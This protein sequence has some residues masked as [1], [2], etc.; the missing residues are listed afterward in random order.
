MMNAG[1]VSKTVIKQG[2]IK[3]RGGRETDEYIASCNDNNNMIT[4]EVGS[5]YPLSWTDGLFSAMKGWA[6]LSRAPIQGSLDSFLCMVVRPSSFRS[7]HVPICMLSCFRNQNSFS[8]SAAIMRVEPVTED[9]SNVDLAVDSHLPRSSKA[10]WESF[11]ELLRHPP[12]LFLSCTAL[13]AKECACRRLRCLRETN[14]EG[15]V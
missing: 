5:D 15:P 4:A 8:V 1:H 9:P 2:R 10:V 12:S 6:T 11:G 7:D 14:C 13:T 3:K